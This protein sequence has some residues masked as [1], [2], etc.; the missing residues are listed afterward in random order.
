MLLRKARRS[1]KCAV[2]RYSQNVDIYEV[3]ER[4]CARNLVIYEVF[5]R[6]Y[7]QHLD[8]YEVCER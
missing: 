6:R 5:E 2:G 4:C 1:G 7:A 3:V 8:I